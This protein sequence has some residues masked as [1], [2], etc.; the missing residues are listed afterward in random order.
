M[1]VVEP[2]PA[3]GSLRWIRQAVNSCPQLLNRKIIGA[4]ELSDDLVVEWL[5][6]LA[7]DD[8]AEYRDQSFLDLAGLQLGEVTLADFWPRR[9]PQWDGLARSFYPSPGREPNAACDQPI[10]TE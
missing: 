10:G 5:S 7:A 2:G 6:P 8:Y 4:G 9:G 1:R 3:R